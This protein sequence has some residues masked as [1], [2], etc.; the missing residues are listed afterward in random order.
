MPGVIQVPFGDTLVTRIEPAMEPA[1]Y[2]TYGLSMPLKT[3]WRPATCEEAGCEAYRFGW[4]T[5]LDLG[6]E[7]GQQWAARLRKDRTRSCTEQRASL[8]LT[9]FVYGPGNTCFQV[10][11][12]KVPVGRPARF[13]VAGGDFRGNPRGTPVRVHKRPEDWCEDF[14]L[15]QQQLATAIE[16]G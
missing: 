10:S 2:K 13:Y 14:A 5:T 16:R 8:T 1:Y 3:H 9:K 11:Q 6:T 7:F 12:H 15:H 4:V